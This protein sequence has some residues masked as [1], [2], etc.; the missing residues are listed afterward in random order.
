M[1]VLFSNNYLPFDSV[2]D[3]IHTYGINRI[4]EYHTII[5]GLL[6]IGSRRA[7]SILQD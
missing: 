4:R 6:A 2:A 1:T 3:Q 5:T 7:F